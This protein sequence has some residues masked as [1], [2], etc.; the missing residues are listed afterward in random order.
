MHLDASRLFRGDARLPRM[1]SY[2]H[3]GIFQL[4]ILLVK[5]LISEVAQEL[6][7]CRSTFV[8]L[9]LQEVR[10]QLNELLYN[11]SRID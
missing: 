8:T 7:V 4:V 11:A 6:M 5:F 1:G 2:K 9:R 3:E 10:R